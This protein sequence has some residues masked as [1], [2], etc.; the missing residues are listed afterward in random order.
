MKSVMRLVH[1][2]DGV[3]VVTHEP[4]RV[5]ATLAVPRIPQKKLPPLLVAKQRL[6]ELPPRR[7]TYGVVT[8]LK[9]RRDQCAEIIDTGLCCGQKVESAYNDFCPHHDAIAHGRVLEAAE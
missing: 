3:C 6:R 7:P 1:I 5:D 8:L 2:R 4:D 9:R